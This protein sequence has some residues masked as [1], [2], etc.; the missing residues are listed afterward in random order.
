MMDSGLGSAFQIWLS[1]ESDRLDAK[2]SCLAWKRIRDIY[3]GTRFLIFYPSRIQLQQQ[4]R[5]ENLL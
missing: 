4:K 3:P 5:E 1:P 2:E